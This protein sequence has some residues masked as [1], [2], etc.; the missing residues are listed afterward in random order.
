MRRIW[1]ALLVALAVAFGAADALAQAESLPRL[2]R[3]DAPRP[4][5]PSDEP[6]VLTADTVTVDRE[7]G[8][9]TA[10]GKVEATQGD[11]TLMADTV[12]YNNRSGVVTATGNVVLMEPSGDVLFAEYVE[13]QSGFRAGVIE[14]FRLLMADGSRLAGNQATRALLARDDLSAG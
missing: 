1:G 13:L 6:A 8:L 12:T 2:R 5:Q 9:T 14:T 4:F 11:R 10:T 3:P 7:L